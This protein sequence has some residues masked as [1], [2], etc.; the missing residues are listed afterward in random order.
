MI[1]TKK[2]TPLKQALVGRSGITVNY[3][4][5]QIKLT[6]GYVDAVKNLMREEILMMRKVHKDSS[7]CWKIGVAEIEDIATANGVSFM[8][9]EKSDKSWLKKHGQIFVE[10]P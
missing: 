6:K 2:K 3:D 7:E 10:V 1:T 4:G 8:F 5:K 9:G